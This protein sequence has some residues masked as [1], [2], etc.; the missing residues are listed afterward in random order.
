MAE[1]IEKVKPATGAVVVV[2]ERG[3]TVNVADFEELP[4]LLDA[5]SVAV[6]VP[7]E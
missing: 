6:Y 2:V 3:G 1:L 7:G 4:A 5:V